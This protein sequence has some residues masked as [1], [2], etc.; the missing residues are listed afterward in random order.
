M[1]CKIIK[2]INDVINKY[3]CFVMPSARGIFYLSTNANKPYA[4]GL[5]G[6][7]NKRKRAR[8]SRQ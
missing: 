6:R 4:K 8:P 5:P 7:N 2:C 1:K 3:S